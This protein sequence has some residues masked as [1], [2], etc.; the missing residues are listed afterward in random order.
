MLWWMQYTTET[1]WSIKESLAYCHFLGRNVLNSVKIFCFWS[2]TQSI[3]CIKRVFHATDVK[4]IE[5]NYSNFISSS[6]SAALSAFGQHLDRERL[7]EKSAFCE[8]RWFV[9]SPTVSHCT[10]KSNN[11][12]LS[13]SVWTRTRSI[14]PWSNDSV[15][16]TGVICSSSWKHDTQVEK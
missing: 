5:T 13:C 2:F 1:W 8:T 6:V 3:W 15:A 9:F 14:T 16:V 10:K 4:K 12:W 11:I 7:Q